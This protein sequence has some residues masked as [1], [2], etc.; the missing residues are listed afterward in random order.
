MPRGR[1]VERDAAR[2]PVLAGRSPDALDSN[3]LG[4]ETIP[5]GRANAVFL[6][7]V[8]VRLVLVVL[9]VLSKVKRQI[10]S[11]ATGVS[12]KRRTRGIER[13]YFPPAVHSHGESCDA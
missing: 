5:A 8:P 9:P 13:V 6:G 11:F 4:T 2:S 12:I 10:L 3:A 7:L 1:R